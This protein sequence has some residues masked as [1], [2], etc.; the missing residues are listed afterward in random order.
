[1][2]FHDDDVVCNASP[3]PTFAEVSQCALSRRRALQGSLSL[4]GVAFLGCGA[5]DPTAVVTALEESA[6]GASDSAQWT[7]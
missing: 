7:A 3:N 2:S 4:A 1:M 6:C 5:E